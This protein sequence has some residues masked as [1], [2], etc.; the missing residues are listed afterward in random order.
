MPAAELQRLEA[1][2]PAPAGVRAF[3]TLRCRRD[4]SPFNLGLR[5]GGDAARANRQ[6]LHAAIG[7]PM[8]PRWLQQVHGI[9]VARFEGEGAGEDEPVADAAVT[10]TPGL[11]LAIL[12]ADCLPVLFAAEDGSEVAAA[13]AGWPGLSAGVR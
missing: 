1:E 5:S 7:T 2:W 9:D 3:T 8:A 13:H 10:R 11:P 4:G 6:A 12:T